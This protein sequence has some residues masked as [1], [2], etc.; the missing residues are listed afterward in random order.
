MGRLFWK[1]FFGFWLTLLLTGFVVGSLVWFHRSD[2][3]DELE[4]QLHNPR[5]EMQVSRFADLLQYG[6]EQALIE[7]LGHRARLSH[8]KPPIFIVDEQGDDLLGRPVTA[9]MLN[10]ARRALDAPDQMAVQ[11]VVTE[12]GRRYLMFVA[13]HEH[14]KRGRGSFMRRGPIPTFFIPLVASLLFSAGLAWYL[15]RP[16]RVLRQATRQFSDGDLGVRVMPAIGSRKDEIAD[17][18]RDFDDMAEHIQSLVSAQKS[19]LNDVSHELRS[20]LA[21]LQ[22]AVEMSR[23][24]PQRVTELLGRVEKESKR[25]DELV[26]EVLTLSRIEAGTLENELDYFDINGLVSAVSSDANFEAENQNKAIIFNDDIEILLQG[27]VELLRRAIENIVRNALHHTPEHSQVSISLTHENNEVVM[28]VCD[29]GSG[30]P[31]DKL[32]Q[33]FQPFVRINESTQN[34]KIPGYGLGL[35]IARRAIE[36]HHGSI[37]ACNRDKGGLCITVRL[38]ETV[39]TG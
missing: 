37:R 21:R 10:Q 7:R 29:S 4:M 39:K 13:R 38:P 32:E 6:G 9:S 36:I 33:L 5:A 28:T 31:E 8:R 19:L 3:I 24:Q 2:R 1:I 22:V 12:Q 23:Q 34:A 27:R 15:T 35:A 16:V 17:L 26:G 14:D 20:P 18:G 30:V 11:E 25:L